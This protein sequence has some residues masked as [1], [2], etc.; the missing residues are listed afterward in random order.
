MSNHTYQITKLILIVA[1]IFVPLADAFRFSATVSLP[2]P[3]PFDLT[4]ES[5]KQLRRI[6]IGEVAQE[7]AGGVDQETAS[8][9]NVKYDLGLGKNKPVNSERAV[10][11]NPGDNDV[12]PTQFLIE[13]ESVRP[14]PSPSNFD[15]ELE[16][17]ITNH[18]RK[19]RK[20]LPKIQHRRHSEDVLQIQDV[21]VIGNP[22]NDCIDGT[23]RYPIIIPVNGIS[24]VGNAPVEKLDVN[25]IWV[26]MM[27]H[28]ERKNSKHVV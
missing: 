28:N 13:H 14:Y 4:I 7:R 10:E 9:R 5:K 15:S 16:S 26:E 11:T 19:N 21:R 18:S 2:I 23:S 22:L 6:E 25:T 20:N 27:I 8:Q 17:K 3:P 24:A 12:E 1:S